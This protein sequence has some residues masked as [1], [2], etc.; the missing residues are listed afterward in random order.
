MATYRFKNP[1]NMKTEV[2]TRNIDIKSEHLQINSY[3]VLND[4]NSESYVE[5]LKRS[6]AVNKNCEAAK[7]QVK[8]DQGS[9][10]T[11]SFLTGRT[12]T[13]GGGGEVS[14]SGKIPLLVRLGGKVNLKYDH[15]RLKSETTTNVDKVTQSVSMEIQ[16]PPNHSCSIDITSTTFTAEVP[17]TAELTRR[18]KNNEQRTTTSTGIYYHQEVTELL[19]IVNPCT[20]VKD[21][22]KCGNE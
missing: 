16:V 5:V 12:N 2:L 15:S 19:T 8:H 11:R 1:E 3:E 13:F 4:K 7:H 6:T 17:Y 14:V 22:R 18:Y 21:G 20:P 9:D 10:Q